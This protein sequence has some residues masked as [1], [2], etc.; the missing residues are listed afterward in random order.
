MVMSH[1]GSKATVE[2]EWL[3]KE[4]LR[5]R[6]SG[7]SV[8][9]LTVAK[10]RVAREERGGEARELLAA[11]VAECMTSTLPFYLEWAQVEFRGLRSTAEVITDKDEKGRYCV[12]MINLNF[13]IDTSEGETTLKKIE[14]VKKML[15]RGCFMSRSLEGGVKVNCSISI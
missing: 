7:K 12:S 4:D 1:L 10:S 11:S 14:R 5:V 13:D 8:D 6:F 9:E 15:D 2:V 3:G